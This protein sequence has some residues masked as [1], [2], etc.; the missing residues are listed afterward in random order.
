VLRQFSD[1]TK[2][3]RLSSAVTNIRAN[4]APE[5]RSIIAL[6]SSIMPMSHAMHRLFQWQRIIGCASTPS[7]EQCATVTEKSAPGCSAGA[8]SCASSL[9]ACRRQ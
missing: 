7:L 6:G 8:G 3:L 9:A 1:T 5:N 4:D 2:A